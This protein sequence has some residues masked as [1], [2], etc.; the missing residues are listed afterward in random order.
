LRPD[1]I[2]LL[3]ED[4]HLIIDSKLSLVNYYDYEAADSEEVRAV[5]L[6]KLIGSVRAHA[7]SLA[8]KRYQSSHGLNAHDLVLMFVP[9]EGVAAV[10][11]KHDNDLYAYTWSRKVVL[12]SPSTL[13]MTMQTVASI[14]RYERQNENAHA[15]AVQAGQLYDKLVGF[16]VD[17][18]DVSQKI[19]AAADSHGAAMNKLSLGRGNALSRAEKLKTLGV[20][21]KKD[22]PAV[23]LGVDKH[24]I[25]ADDDEQPEPISNWARLLE[26]PAG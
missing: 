1:V 17:L 24:V 21:P 18:N 22:F 25:E 4:R 11:L 6:K 12:V 8:S 7:D 15:I 23:L 2:V 13:F 20:S 10:V 16:V 5:A 9:I 14:W 26:K 19:Q 3:P